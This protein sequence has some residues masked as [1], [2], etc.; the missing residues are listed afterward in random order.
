MKIRL[1]KTALNNFKD[2]R[3]DKNE[4]SRRVDGFPIQILLPNSKE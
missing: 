4:N 3:G 1:K 2:Y